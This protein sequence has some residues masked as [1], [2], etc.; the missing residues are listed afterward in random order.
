MQEMPLPCMPPKPLLSGSMLLANE[1]DRVETGQADEAGEERFELRSISLRCVMPAFTPCCLTGIET[2]GGNG[3]I[4]SFSILP[5]LMRD[6]IV[7]ENW[8]GPT[9]RS[10]P[11][12]SETV[13]V[14]DFMT[15]SRL[16]RRAAQAVPEQ[17][18]KSKTMSPKPSQSVSLRLTEV[19]TLKILRSQ[20][21]SHALISNNS[22]TS[23]LQSLSL[24][25][26]HTS[27]MQRKSAERAQSSP[28]FGGNS[29]KS[30][31]N[32]T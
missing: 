26:S 27:P 32:K 12:H 18:A 22:R 31:L 14:T 16:A 9:I 10:W 28:G 21:Y 1:L 6:N 13:P 5:R 23:S 7:Y 29:A 30:R 3:A 17:Y 19:L 11:R 2:L 20:S 4:E 24:E 8:E 15:L 25:I